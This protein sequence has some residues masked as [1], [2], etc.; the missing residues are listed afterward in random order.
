VIDELLGEEAAVQNR[1]LGQ[2]AAPIGIRGIA[3]RVNAHLDRSWQECESG[4]RGKSP[5]N[6]EPQ[7]VAS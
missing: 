6:K 5:G 1:R 7:D 4:K 3:P 2:G